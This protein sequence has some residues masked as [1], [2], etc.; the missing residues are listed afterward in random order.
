MN[1]IELANVL[2]YFYDRFPNITFILSGSEVG[3][4]EKIICE[5][6][7]EV[8][9]HPLYGR[10]IV[11]ITLGRLEKEKAIEFLRK[12]F[13]QLGKEI[14]KDDMK[15]IDEVDGLIGWL[16]YYGYEKAVLKNKDAFEKTIQVATQIMASELDNFLMK[17]K[18]KKLYLAILRNATK[19]SWK[20]LKIMVTKD[21]RKFVNP[22]AF[23]KA[24][25][26]LVEFSFLE[27][28]N[29]KY[30]VADPLVFRALSLVS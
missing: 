25:T 20:E 14:S 13:K 6:K 26:T 24:L 9:E 15:I 30:F 16:T 2:S 27:K 5:K 29:G 11:K 7:E 19:V 18:N 1:N 10:H 4:L 21:L 3:L 8:K 22:N 28:E 23:S 12:G 17:R